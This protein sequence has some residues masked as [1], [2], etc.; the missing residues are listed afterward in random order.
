MADATKTFDG[1]IQE[2]YQV[3]FRFHPAEALDAGV[4]GY[5][6]LLPAVD[7]DDMGALAS[8]LESLV[9]SLGELDFQSL[10]ADRQLDLQLLFGACQ[11]ELY[12]LLEHD[13]RHR[14]P[15]RFLP[16]RAVHQL[17]LHPQVDLRGVLEGCLS[18]IPEYLRYARSQL[19]T[20]PELI[21]APWL[22]AACS[23][24]GAGI[25]YLRELCDSVL[26]RRLCSNPARIQGLCDE[27]IAAVE[28]YLH[29]LREDIGGR[30]R[31]GMGCG[32]QRFARLLGRRHFLDLTLDQLEALAQATLE[33]VQDELKAL[34]H[35]QN[36]SEDPELWL[37]ALH[38]R[39]PLS[40]ADMLEFVRAQSHSLHNFML[41]RGLAV[42]PAEARLRV[43]EAPASLHTATCAPIYVPPPPGDPQLSG[44]LYFNLE[45]APACDRQPALLTGQCIRDGWPGRHLQAVM[46]AMGPGAGT[47]PRQLHNSATL[48]EGWPLYAEQWLH[49]QGFSPA[50]EQRLV[51]LLE[52]LRRAQLAVLDLEVHAQGLESDKALQRLVALPGMTAARAEADLLQLSRHPSHALAAIVGYR[53]IEALRDEVKEADTFA[54]LLQQGPAAAPLVMRR[55]FGE[56]VWAAVRGRLIDQLSCQ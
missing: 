46:A 42:L 17:L 8:W 53:L 16:V 6:G 19:S 15:V 7:D 27:A 49:D 26:V 55:V 32:E 45:D 56:T 51:S 2:F 20:F 34:C 12:A 28:A 4:S 24:G 29:F 40:A 52:R 50:S 48:A 9:V 30:A 25:R 44:T 3:W 14:D 10:D 54:R 23:E 31:G 37:K 5:E 21:P 38:R 35:E 36:G 33:Q 11:S 18:H 47:L 1:L 43:A 41:E 39:S 13:W 22:Q